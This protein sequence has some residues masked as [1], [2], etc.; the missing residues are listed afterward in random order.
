MFII[1]NSLAFNGGSTFIIRIAKEYF[2]RKEKIGV[3][4]L[5]DA[6]DINLKKELAKVADVFILKD[7]I[8][9]PFK[10]IS[11]YHLGIFYPIRFNELKDTIKN[12][13]NHIHVMGIFSLLFSVRIIQNTCSQF[14]VSAGVYHQY[15][16]MFNSSSY[17]TS[18]SQKIFKELK[19]N[20]VFFI[21]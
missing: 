19:N 20:I 7:Y 1:A 8:K 12:Y 13:G 14:S 11:Y 21:I 10:F 3:L 9:I 5:V 18:Y 15:E 4:I 6:I 16:Y 17:L 2:R